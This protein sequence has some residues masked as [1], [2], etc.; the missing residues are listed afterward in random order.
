MS[1]GTTVSPRGRFP[2][3]RS[4]VIVPAV[5][6]LLPGGAADLDSL[7]NLIDFLLDAGADGIL[8]LGSSGEAVALRARERL[9]IATAATAHTRGRT[10]L[11]LGVATL[12]TADMADETAALAALCPDSLLV[13]APAGLA[14]SERELTGHFRA[15][16]QAAAG[17][18]VIAY[19]VPS[20]V[21]SSLGS[22][23]IASLAADEVIA[24]VKDSSGDLGNG[25]AIAAA[26]RGLGSFVRY[27]GSELCVDAALLAGF[28]GA[29]PGLANVFPEFHVELVRRAAAGDW[30]GA[31][32]VQ[33]LL[34]K[35]IELYDCPLDGGGFPARFFAVVK[36]A[37]R[38][39]G[40]L[41][42]G[43]TSAPLTQAGREVGEHAGALLRRARELAEGVL[44]G[45]LAGA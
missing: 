5:S 32:A 34:A 23:L 40:V 31:S 16:R 11:M 43:T 35:L 13:A 12:G 2:L 26:T 28:D 8:L 38:Q 39:R 36:E 17:L 7:R 27:T 21:G 4:A 22:G 9:R 19:E 20:R 33:E 42:H 29:V 18:P 30:A 41:A 25:R 24:G 10:H 37:L 44:G 45:S 15:A 3:P 6:P 14:L 1:A